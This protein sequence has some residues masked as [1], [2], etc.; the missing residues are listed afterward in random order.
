MTAPTPPTD[1]LPKLA[2]DAMGWTLRSENPGKVGPRC[3][4]DAEGVH[5]FC[6][7][8]GFAP[9]RL[10]DHAQIL[11]E[12]AVKH[13]FLREFDF[14][15]NV[16]RPMQDSWELAYTATPEEKTRAFLKAHQ[17]HFKGEK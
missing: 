5:R 12:Y 10:H 13:G 3:W 1:A 2:A 8:P 17:Q 4:H 11:I 16:L 7:C 9:H 15:L 14:Q 6:Q